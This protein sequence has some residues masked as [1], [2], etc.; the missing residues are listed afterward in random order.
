MPSQRRSSASASPH[1]SLA[2]TISRSGPMS[3]SASGR[4]AR[5][6]VLRVGRLSAMGLCDEVRR[7]C[8]TVAAGARAVAVEVDALGVV[9]P[10]PPPELDRERHYLEGPREDV[11]M[12]M[13]VLDAVNFGSGWFPT[14]RK[15]PD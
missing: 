9:E 5:R 4:S 2:L 12:Y 1:H 3:S 14:L 15:R 7:H 11:A 13:L 6:S 8:A 10:G